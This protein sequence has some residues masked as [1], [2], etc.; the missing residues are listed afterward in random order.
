MASLI[1]TLEVLQKQP[2]PLFYTAGQVI[3]AQGEPS[4]V[5]YGIL[6][7]EVDLIFH[8]QTVET[9]TAGDV[10]G[11]AALVEERPRTY[12]AITKTDCHIVTLDEQHFL[13]AVQELP[14]FA[15]E[16]MQSYVTR[17]EQLWAIEEGT[18]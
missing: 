17:L 7:G 6:N 5:M 18:S 15:L 13:F 8:G 2:A 12:T 10:F 3:F 4:D 16:V 11:I 14:M 9:L 1:T